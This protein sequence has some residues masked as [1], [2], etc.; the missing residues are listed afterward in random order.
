[1][2]NFENNEI[3]ATEEITDLMETTG[4]TTGS[5]IA[6]GLGGAVIF[7][8]LVSAGI[9]LFKRLRN[10]KKEAVEEQEETEE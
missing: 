5:K 7:S 6:I 8:G 10:R 9:Y 2:E 3:M 1:M 4:M